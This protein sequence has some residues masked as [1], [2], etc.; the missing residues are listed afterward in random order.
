MKSLLILAIMA[1]AGGQGCG[2][3]ALNALSEVPQPLLS[4]HV[5]VSG[6]IKQ[7]QPVGT[8]AEV[9]HLRAAVVWGETVTADR[10][11]TWVQDANMGQQLPKEPPYNL[12]PDASQVAVAAA[13]CR[14]IYDFVPGTVGPSAPVQPDGTAR[15]DFDA[16]PRSTVLVGAPGNR[17]GYAA[18]VVFDDRSTNQVLDL[19]QAQEAAGKGGPGGGG[20][21]GGDTGGGPGGPVGPGSSATAPAKGDFLYGTTFLSMLQPNQ[22]LSYVEGVFDPKNLY[23]GN[24][25]PMIGCNGPATG[26]SRIAVSGSFQAPT[27]TTTPLSTAID[28]ALQVTETVRSAICRSQN[29]RYRDTE[30]PEPPDLK[31]P[32]ACLNTNELLVAYPPGECKGMTHYQLRGCRSD[33]ACKTPEPALPDVL[34]KWWPCGDPHTNPPKTWVK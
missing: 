23:Y 2:S 1:A 31:Q 32:W 15:I 6:D 4:L 17:L 14:D 26:F 28:I 25:Y 27:C 12:P 7:F 21:P 29:P 30:R 3:D 19:K 16:L 8:E 18:I 20:G 24:F 9:P 22:R 13:G 10:F 34:P 5:K 33:E 11:C